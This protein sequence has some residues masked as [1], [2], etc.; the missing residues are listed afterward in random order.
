MY[1]SYILRLAL[2]QKKKT[3]NETMTNDWDDDAIAITSTF[4]SFFFI[5]LYRFELYCIGTELS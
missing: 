3:V 4:T 5:Y 2:H 1:F